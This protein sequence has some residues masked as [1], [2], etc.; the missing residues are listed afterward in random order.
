MYKIRVVNHFPSARLTSEASTCNLLF[1]K[2]PGV[3]ASRLKIFPV[4]PLHRGIKNIVQKD[5]L[6]KLISFVCRTSATAGHICRETK[7]S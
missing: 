7:N 6:A 5:S 4:P 2:T 1:F 3:F